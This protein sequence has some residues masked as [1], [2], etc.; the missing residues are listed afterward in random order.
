MYPSKQ[1]RKRIRLEKN[2][3]PINVFW[4]TLIAANRASSLISSNMLKETNLF[5]TIFILKYIIIK[6]VKRNF[7][8]S[9]EKM[10]QEEK[11]WQKETFYMSRQ[12]GKSNLHSVYWLMYFKI[13]VKESNI[14]I[15]W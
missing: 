13:V 8:W 10:T 6:N 9:N 3:F 14:N 7:R 4:N 2:F 12:E 15:K 11:K 1:E 5:K